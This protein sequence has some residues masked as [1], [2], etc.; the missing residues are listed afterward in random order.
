M[1]GG[2]AFCVLEWVPK[3]EISVNVRHGSSRISRFVVL[4]S[5]WHHSAYITLCHP[6]RASYTI[7]S[8]GMNDNLALVR[9]NTNLSGVDW[10]WT[11]K[12]H[13]ACHLRMNRRLEYF[14]DSF[15][16]PTVKFI[17]ELQASFW[18]YSSE[19]PI[20]WEVFTSG[21]QHIRY[22]MVILY[23]ESGTSKFFVGRG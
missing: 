4:T 13:H 17:I 2:Q 18:V 1:G 10:C 3:H 6:I 14:C 5:A 21:I 19:S 23:P 15:G 9:T 22:H 20:R 12:R 7:K 16:Q 11:R 8:E